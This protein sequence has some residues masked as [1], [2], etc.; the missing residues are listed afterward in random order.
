MYFYKISKNCVLKF[1]FP[2]F[3]IKTS[4]IAIFWVIAI[5]S[6][7]AFVHKRQQNKICQKVNVNIDNEYDNYF[8]ENEDVQNLMAKNDQIINNVHAFITLKVL[9]NRIKSHGFVEKVVVSKDLSGGIDVDVV[10]YQPLVRLAIPG[11]TDAYLSSG[12]KILPMS[13][14]FT[15]RCMVLTGAFTTLL[16]Q[17]DWQKDSL[18]TPYFN[19]VKKIAA[20]EFLSSLLPQSDIN[21][22]GEI[23]IYPQVGKQVIDF[24]KP[25]DLD[26]KFAKLQML[27]KKII[28]A[29]GWNTY[30][31]ISLKYKNQIICE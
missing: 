22:K 14:R 26:I 24:G 19:F 29:K 2:K 3:K 17:K 8:I 6:L 13:S 23:I 10:Q 30:T 21:W 25:T 27:Y 15:A 16:A 1:Q 5:F 12:G 28:P 7:M 4:V 20:D 9:E 18:R 11:Q 31:Y